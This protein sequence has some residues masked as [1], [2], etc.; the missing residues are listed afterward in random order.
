MKREILSISNMSFE[1]YLW[2]DCYVPNPMVGAPLK[3]FLVDWVKSRTQKQRL[4]MWNTVAEPST[5][6]VVH[7]L[8]DDARGE[9][10]V[11][12]PQGKNYN[13]LWAGRMPLGSVVLFLRGTLRECKMLV[14]GDSW[15]GKN[16]EEIL[17]I[18]KW[19]NQQNIMES[20]MEK[21]SV[22]SL[23]SF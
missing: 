18:L 23:V 11:V 13:T 4:E 2:S 3:E 19:A 22:L 8:P 10:E 1:E 6:A 7:L 20:I 5:G 14:P 9:R 17:E 15:P 21:K 12:R 16:E